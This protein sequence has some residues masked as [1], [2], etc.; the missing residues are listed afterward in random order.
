MHDALELRG[1]VSVFFCESLKTQLPFR[2]RSASS[3]DRVSEMIESILRN[4]EGWTH[5]PAHPLFRQT[6]LL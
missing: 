1:K 4:I 2:L 6:D 5:R 3:R